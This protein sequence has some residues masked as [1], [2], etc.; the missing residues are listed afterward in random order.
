MLRNIVI[1][2]L[3]TA[4][5]PASV[6]GCGQRC[7]L[8]IS[9]KQ[10]GW[11]SPNELYLKYVQPSVWIT[12]SQIALR[13]HTPWWCSLKLEKLGLEKRKKEKQKAFNLHIILVLT[14]L[15]VIFGD[16]NASTIGFKVTLSLHQNGIKQWPS[17]EG[18]IRKTHL[19][20][21]TCMHL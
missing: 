10:Q 16:D 6:F 4:D 12:H 5:E 3:Q 20:S 8:A 7:G 11:L 14:S 2:R 19:H 13:L 15:Q 1:N 9:L 21:N 18:N 17:P